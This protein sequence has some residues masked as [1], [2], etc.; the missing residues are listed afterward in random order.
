MV[1]STW[2]ALHGA[3][4]RD[5]SCQG[6][7]LWYYLT[8]PQL[9]ANGLPVVTYEHQSIVVEDA[10]FLRSGMR[11]IYVHVRRHANAA[12]AAASWRG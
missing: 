9:Q 7:D 3:H 10:R 12:S 4:T 2:P 11:F 1:I 5:A 8:V 6:A